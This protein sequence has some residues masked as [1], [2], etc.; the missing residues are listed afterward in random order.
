[1]SHTWHPCNLPNSNESTLFSCLVSMVCFFSFL[2]IFQRVFFKYF[3]ILKLLLSLWLLPLYSQQ[4]HELLQLPTRHLN[5][6]N[7]PHHFV[8]LAWDRSVD[9][10]MVRTKRCLLSKDVRPWP[11]LVICNQRC[12]KVMT[13]ILSHRISDFEG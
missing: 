12:P 9:V 6:T 2:W 13:K 4:W 7:L 10:Y 5:S 1:M 11:A 3:Y 8:C